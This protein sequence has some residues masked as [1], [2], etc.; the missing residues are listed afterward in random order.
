MILVVDCETSGLLVKDK[1]LDSPEQPRIVQLAFIVQDS[2]R[3]TVH[4]YSG[5]M[6]PPDSNG[7]AIS[8]EAAAVHGITTETCSRYGVHPRVALLDFASMLETVRILVG[9]N[10]PFDLALLKREI[11]LLD[12]PYRKQVMLRLD[13][14]RLRRVDTMKVA[15]TLT[16]DGRW[17]TLARAHKMLTGLDLADAHNALAD[18][19]ASARIFWSLCDRRLC[20][21]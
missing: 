5:L 12:E 2:N 9:Y 13:R 19:S 1:P 15:A 4:E 16:A 17:P 6:K 20:E 7:W 10:L 14:P 11:D 8:N 3:K 18:A 21:L